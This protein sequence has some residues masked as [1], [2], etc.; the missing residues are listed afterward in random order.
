MNQDSDRTTIWNNI[1]A[2]YYIPSTP[3][4]EHINPIACAV[5]NVSD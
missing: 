1:Q 3:I 4:V 2:N 5:Q